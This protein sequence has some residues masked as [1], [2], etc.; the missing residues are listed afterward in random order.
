METTTTTETTLDDDDDDDALLFGGGGGSDGSSHLMRFAACNRL[1]VLEKIVPLL[2]ERRSRY[3]DGE[4][5]VHFNAS[6][7]AACS[8][9]CRRLVVDGKR[10]R[11]TRAEVKSIA[12]AEYLRVA[13]EQRGLPL[14]A[15][16]FFQIVA[17]VTPQQCA[18]NDGAMEVLRV[19]R[20]EYRCPFDDWSTQAA[21]SDE[22]K[23]SLLRWLVTMGC[24]VKKDAMIVAS[25]HKSIEAVSF[26]LKTED[27]KDL[28][29]ERCTEN[30]AYMGNLEMLVYLK[31]V[32]CPWSEQT[33]FRAAYKGHSDVFWWLHRND[34]PID[35]VECRR[36]AKQFGYLDIVEGLDNYATEFMEKYLAIGTATGSRVARVLAARSI[37]RATE[38]PA[39]ERIIYHLRMIKVIKGHQESRKSIT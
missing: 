22:S 18:R 3:L 13:I 29:D 35:Y 14:E 15:E 7:F 32:G 21:A 8:K 26:L 10:R 12:D 1:V 23:L 37:E 28:L 36:I 9:A 30:A 5:V 25:R 11:L 27:G 16:T 19:L 34:C 20:E 6:N 38:L 17:G 24:P 33:S 39:E 4:E 2:G 31:S